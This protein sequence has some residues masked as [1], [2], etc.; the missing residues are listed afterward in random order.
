MGTLARCLSTRSW[1]TRLVLSVCDPALAVVTVDWSFKRLCQSVFRPVISGRR[2][3]VAISVL[4]FSPGDSARSLTIPDG[5]VDSGTA[6]DTVCVVICTSS[7]CW[8]TSVRAISTG[9]RCKRRKSELKR[10]ALVAA[11][12]VVIVRCV[13]AASV[14]EAL[15]QSGTFCTYRL[16]VFP[17]ILY[18]KIVSL[19]ERS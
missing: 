4:P 7:V 1:L 2:S 19:R 13:Q 9:G 15:K 12:S 17:N 8:R 6:V 11:Q 3:P 14:K 10:R 18:I 16:E 5:G